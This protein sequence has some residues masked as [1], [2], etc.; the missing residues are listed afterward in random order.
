MLAAE[1]ERTTNEEQRTAYNAILNGPHAI[2][3]L[4]TVGG[5]GKTSGLNAPAQRTR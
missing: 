5:T 1:Q 2:C 3:S 4:N